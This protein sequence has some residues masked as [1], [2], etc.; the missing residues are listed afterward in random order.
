MTSD[1]PV[2]RFAA[3]DGLE[4]AWREVGDGRPLVMLHGLMSGGAQLIS[5]ENGPVQ[6]FASRGHRVIVPDLRGHGDSGRPHD[7]AWYPPDVLADDG[8]ALIER[9]GLDD[10]DLGGYSLGGRV[11][12]RLLARG[13]WPARAFVGGQGL[14]ALDAESDRTSG[15]RALLAAMADGAAFESGSQEDRMAAWLRQI[16]ADPRAVGHVLNTFT[17]TPPDALRNVTSPVLVVVGDADSR[18][19]TAAELT[20]LLP[21]GQL[22]I[23]K[24][25][26]GEQQAG[27]RL[28]VVL[29]ERGEQG[30][31][32]QAAR[33]AQVVANGGAAFGQVQQDGAAVGRV[34]LAADQPGF[35]E[36]V[37]HRGERAGHDAQPVGE[38]RHPQRGVA[39]G[40]RAQRAFLRRGEA[41]RRELLPLGTAQPPGQPVEQVR[42]LNRVLIPLRAVVA[43]R[44]RHDTQPRHAAHP[45]KSDPH[46]D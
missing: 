38:L 41:E 35:L 45:T 21:N 39:A 5:L 2:H 16:G 9:L 31:G 13:A 32:G 42:E 46:T 18:G 7:P 27:E 8:L 23:V 36:R 26:E 40:D 28:A 15:H 34:D 29:A 3:R 30:F 20:A 25:T 12:L 1:L 14:D 43:A 37:D 22:V 10:Y 33:L 4:L 24:L 6:A 17:A 11:V 19:T 44:G